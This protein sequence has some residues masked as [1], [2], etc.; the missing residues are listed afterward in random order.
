MNKGH[1][2]INI[3]KTLTALLEKGVTSPVHFKNLSSNVEE[4]FTNLGMP[5]MT[6]IWIMRNL[7]DKD[8]PRKRTYTTAFDESEMME[9]KLIDTTPSDFFKNSS[10]KTPGVG[11]MLPP[12]FDPTPNGI[13]QRLLKPD[14]S[15]EP[16]AEIYRTNG[17]LWKLLPGGV[18]LEMMNKSVVQ[19]R[20]EMLADSLGLFRQREAGLTPCY[21]LLGSPSI[22]TSSSSGK[23]DGCFGMIHNNEILALGVWINLGTEWSTCHP[24]QRKAA[25][26]YGYGIAMGLLGIGIKAQDILVPIVSF[27][28][29]CIQ[30]GSVYMLEPS[31]PVYTNISPALDLAYEQS[32]M[33]AAAFLI[34]A[35]AHV[36]TVREQVTKLL[37]KVEGKPNLAD[38]K[39]QLNVFNFT[40]NDDD[41]QEQKGDC[42]YHLKLLQE[43]SFFHGTGTEG[44][45]CWRNAC[46]RLR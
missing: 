15:A 2:A 19:H 36:H 4:A 22:L 46:P 11:Y 8:S 10:L 35:K 21:S 18:N 16:T 29:K 17:I 14:R 40:N 43:K 9:T 37:S 38:M 32:S 6:S 41:G 30:F 42:Q 27:N 31:F 28:G 39:M 24:D 20:Y 45:A 33:E 23:M 5:S 26:A 3:S 12:H 25:I 44:E 34:K 7:V 1:T 13:I